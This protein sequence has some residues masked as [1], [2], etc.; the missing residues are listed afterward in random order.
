MKYDLGLVYMQQSGPLHFF[1]Y[2][3]ILDAA[4]VLFNLSY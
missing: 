1:A 3:W 4:S 2:K